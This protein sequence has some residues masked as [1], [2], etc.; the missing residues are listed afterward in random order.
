MRAASK[1][2]SA[3]LEAGTDLGISRAILSSLFIGAEL[4]VHVGQIELMGAEQTAIGIGAAPGEF[5]GLAL[6]VDRA[7]ERG[8]GFG[9]LAGL[10]QQL[11][12]LREH[13]PEVALEIDGL[14]CACD[15]LFEAGHGLCVGCIGLGQLVL[16]DQDSR[17]GC[18]GRSSGYED[19]CWPAT[20]VPEGETRGR[21]SRGRPSRHPGRWRSPR[22]F[23]KPAW[24]RIDSLV[25]ALA[26]LASNRARALR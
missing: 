17:P 11:A 3:R 23:N 13:D 1:Q 8:F 14:G 20:G 22:L 16:A 12:V 25:C 15:E 18:S 7:L 24:I 19:L 26:S 4:E 6:M 9:E 5:H 2:P 10:S 21:S